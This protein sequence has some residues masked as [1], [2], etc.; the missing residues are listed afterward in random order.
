M[1]H[2]QFSK[3]CILNRSLLEGDSIIHKFGVRI[4]TGK[5]G[6]L[7]SGELAEYL[8]AKLTLLN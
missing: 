4:Q 1:L 2:K 7:R 5:R 8:M 3:G 6:K